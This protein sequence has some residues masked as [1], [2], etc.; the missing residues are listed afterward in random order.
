M[1]IRIQSS[2]ATPAVVEPLMKRQLRG[3]LRRL[4]SVVRHI[5]VR[6]DDQ[7]QRAGT[8]DKRCQVQV[9]L[10]G[11]SL[12]RIDVRSRHWPQ[13]LEAATTRLKQRV[14]ARLRQQAVPAAI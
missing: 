14:V 5:H 11:G 12:A 7:R 13:A 2:P 4:R 3:A 9:E 8:P 6:L 10:H 1:K